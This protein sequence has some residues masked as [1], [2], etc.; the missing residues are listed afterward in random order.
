MTFKRFAY[1]ISGNHAIV[2][3]VIA[4]IKRHG[5]GDPRVNIQ[6]HKGKAKPYQVRQVLLA[7]EKIE[8]QHGS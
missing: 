2:V 8:V 1:I 4:S 6:N 3:V 7:I 5:L